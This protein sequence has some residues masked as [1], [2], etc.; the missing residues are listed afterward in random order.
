MHTV[1]L[2]AVLR[3]SSATASAL[4]G[5]P[6]LSLTRDPVH[7]LHLII[8]PIT[9]GHTKTVRLISFGIL[10]SSPVVAQQHVPTLPT[11]DLF[12]LKVIYDSDTPYLSLEPD[13]LPG[14]AALN[15][16]CTALLNSLMYLYENYANTAMY[17][18]NLGKYY[19]IPPPYSGWSQL[20]AARPSPRFT[21]AYIT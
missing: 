17:I 4:C 20:H 14:D 9:M 10:L 18:C 19:R 15:A 6:L 12:D 16:R 1:G 21:N 7:S 2:S 5:V 11:K 3:S 13:S 8:Q